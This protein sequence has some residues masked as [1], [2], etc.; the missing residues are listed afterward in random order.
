[1]Y[2]RLQVEVARDFIASQ[3]AA[4][5]KDITMVAGDWLSPEVLNEQFDLGYDY[6]FA[7]LHS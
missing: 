5:G 3:E 4:V 7:S 1:M 6:T 2:L